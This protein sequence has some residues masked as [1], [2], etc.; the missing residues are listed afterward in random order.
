MGY[1][2]LRINSER[3]LRL[4]RTY[5][6]TN[7]TPAKRVPNLLTE[8]ENGSFLALKPRGHVEVPIGVVPFAGQGVSPWPNGNEGVVRYWKHRMTIS[9]EVG[10]IS[11]D[12]QTPSPPRGACSRQRTLPR[13]HSR[14]PRL[15]QQLGMDATVFA[16]YDYHIKALIIGQW[17]LSVLLKS[18]Q[19]CR[20]SL[21]LSSKIE[22][23]WYHTLAQ[24]AR[25]I[26]LRNTR[27]FWS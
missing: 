1:E 24:V 14:V 25:R 6:P 11:P 26:C 5:R 7:C 15:R 23:T 3:A 17:R 13:L 27:T 9:R 18:P 8:R 4:F 21:I 16:M 12:T 19:H 10:L 2:H 20:F 22:E